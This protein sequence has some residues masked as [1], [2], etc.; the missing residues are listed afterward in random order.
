MYSAKNNLII[1]IDT[2]DLNKAIN[3]AKQLKNEIHAVKL[4]LEFFTKNGAEGV[5]KI[6]SLGVEIFLDLK[7]HDIPNTVAKAVNEIVNLDINML[8][9]HSQGGY[10]MM[11]LAQ[12]SAKKTAQ[13][14]GCKLPIIL[15]VTI[16]TS[17]DE[18]IFKQ[19]NS[20]QKIADQ[21]L[22]LAR[23]AKKANIPGIVCSPHEI[24]LVKKNNLN[25]KIIAPGI[26][27]SDSKSN[28]Q[29]RIMT[30]KEALDLGA[31]YLV[32]GR[33]ILDGGDIMA[34]IAKFNKEVS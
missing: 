7:F 32:M 4:G 30:P 13:K 3:L 1:A 11:K 6:R 18:K 22:T 19:I 14:N 28:D 34:N 2:A 33:P 31:N 8:T 29:K 20:R 26:R 21:V 27:F 12:D 16:L 9:I 24:E 17:L 15:A 23:I 5:K 25:L 10:E